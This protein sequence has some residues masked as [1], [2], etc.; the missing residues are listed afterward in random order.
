MDLHFIPMLVV[1]N[2]SPMSE[3]IGLA[4]TGHRAVDI[5]VHEAPD[6]S[7]VKNVRYGR[8]IV[9]IE[10]A[11][12]FPKI[13]ASIHS[14]LRAAEIHALVED[15][16]TR[17][18]YRVPRGYWLHAAAFDD[19]IRELDHPEVAR[20]AGRPLLVEDTALADWQAVIGGPETTIAP[21]GP[22][23]GRRLTDQ[24]IIEKADQMRPM[25]VNDIAKLM[26][27]EPGYS[28]AGNERVRNLLKGRYKRVGRAGNKSAD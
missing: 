15:P 24:Q 1:G 5:I 22:K 23:D 9:S 7:L 19:V 28:D 8:K 17:R 20:F 2:V 25:K 21:A 12:A 11:R 16:A 10:A 14:A 4:S 27:T 18:F 3:M 6:G 26:C 13:I